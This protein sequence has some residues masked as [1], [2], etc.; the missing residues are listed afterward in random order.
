MCTYVGPDSGAL[1]G[2]CTGTPGYIAN[3][4]IEQIINNSSFT[5]QQISSEVA[6]DILIYDST[7]WVSWMTQSTYDAR[8]AWAQSL[9]YGVLA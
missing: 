1:P 6:G 2:Q 3:W 4:E 7:Q 9:G 5:V 8:S